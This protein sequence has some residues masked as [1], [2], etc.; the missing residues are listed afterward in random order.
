MNLPLCTS[1]GNPLTRYIGT[2]WDIHSGPGGAG[3]SQYADYNAHRSISTLSFECPWSYRHRVRCSCLSG[4]LS[5]D[6]FPE[7]QIIILSRAL[8]PLG[9]TSWQDKPLKPIKKAVCLCVRPS[10]TFGIPVS[11]FTVFPSLLSRQGAFGK[12]DW[13]SLC[14]DL[15][16]CLL[17]VF[18]FRCI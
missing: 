9:R 1:D 8:D 13:H 15:I 3:P 11:P 16:L 17:I 12:S 18:F 10:A 5:E 6:R 2:C 7:R 4:N 14:L